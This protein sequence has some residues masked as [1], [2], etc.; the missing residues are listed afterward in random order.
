MT[1]KTSSTILLFLASMLWGF[2]FVA[3]RMGMDYVGVYTFGAVRFLLGAVILLPVIALLEKGT[4]PEKKRG[5]WQ[6]GAMAGLALFAA[7]TLQQYGIKLI[8]VNGAGKAGF[9]TGIYIILVPLLGLFLKQRTKAWT[10]IGAVVALGGLYFLSVTDGWGSVSLGDIL[11]LIGAFF[12]AI[13]ILTVDRFSGRGSPLRFAAVQFLVCGTLSAVCALVLEE[14]S[15][16]GLA[17]AWLPLGYSVIFCVGFAYSFQAI[18][19]KHV[20]PGPA[21]VI[22]STEALFSAVGGYFILNETMGGRSLLGCAL[23]FLGILAVN[24]EALVGLLRRRRA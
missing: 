20:G 2:A 24:A 4:P 7:A 3:Q 23:I 9:I 6:G 15:L 18:G 10:W 21:A 1:K 13:H 19:Q 12:W 22:F 16:A 14:I 11:T 8:P 5:S 17:Q